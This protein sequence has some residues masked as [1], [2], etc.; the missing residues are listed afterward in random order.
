MS[1]VL[2]EYLH[3]ESPPGATRCSGNRCE[4]NGKP[5]AVSSVETIL[6]FSLLPDTHTS[7]AVVVP[8]RYTH[9]LCSTYIPTYL[10]R[11]PRCPTSLCPVVQMLSTTRLAATGARSLVRNSVSSRAAHFCSNGSSSRGSIGCGFLIKERRS[12]KPNSRGVATSSSALAAFPD[13]AR[14]GF[15]RDS[16]SWSCHSTSTTTTSSHPR[17]KRLLINSSPPLLRLL[18]SSSSSSATRPLTSLS[19]SHINMAKLTT[20]LKAPNG[21]EFTLPTGLFINNEFVEATGG[22]ITSISPM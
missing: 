9:T 20:Q 8:A 19:Q 13:L 12:D 14:A 7:M 10:T 22:K 11:R 6:D 4:T 16:N 3:A 17:T 1:L 2:Y 5:T 21:V 18:S 15:Y